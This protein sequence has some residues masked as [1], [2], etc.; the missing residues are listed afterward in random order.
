MLPYSCDA[1]LPIGPRYA[2]QKFR[3][4]ARYFRLTRMTWEEACELVAFLHV[5]PPRY[6]RFVFHWTDRTYRKVKRL[7]KRS[8]LVEAA[9]SWAEENRRAVT[10]DDGLR[11]LD[12]MRDGGW[13]VGMLPVVVRHAVA[14]L[15]HIGWTRAEVCARTGLRLHQL[16]VLTNSKKRR[17]SVL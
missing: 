17:V 6:A 16:K 7:M 2:S 9:A 4:Y 3:R 11:I 14:E 13:R 5:V 10:V 1:L 8:D 15:R 12:A